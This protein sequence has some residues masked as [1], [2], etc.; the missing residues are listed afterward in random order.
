M[1]HLALPISFG[2]FLEFS[3][4]I[5]FKSFLR[6]PAGREVAGLMALHVR[7]AMCP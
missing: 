6:S 2:I 1:K 7:L 5:G 4:K 3:G